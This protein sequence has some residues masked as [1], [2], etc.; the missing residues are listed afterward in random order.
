[1]S[2]KFLQSQNRDRS[3]RQQN[4][5]IPTKSFSFIVTKSANPSNPTQQNFA[6]KP[7]QIQNSPN[8]NPR[9]LEAGKYL[10]IKNQKLISSQDNLI[11]SNEKVQSIPSYDD[12]CQPESLSNHESD[13][14]L[15]ISDRLGHV[16]GVDSYSHLS[17][18]EA[19]V[20]TQVRDQQ[21]KA[22]LRSSPIIFSS[23]SSRHSSPKKVD[24]IAQKTNELEAI[25]KE[26]IEKYKKL[27]K[28]YN[29][30]LEKHTESET[31]NEKLIQN[32]SKEINRLKTHQEPTKPQENPTLSLVLEE[33]KLIKER[34]DIIEKSQ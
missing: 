34:L 16:T 11:P 12:L 15:L 29:D 32:L 28:I 14:S 31:S 7:K 19:K 8:I 20:L 2:Y 5:Q 26:E 13:H 4:P 3:R 17:T 22:E 27:E 24:S 9:N 23:V 6:T 1:M 33:I 30:L 18:E 10:Y 25:F 21:P